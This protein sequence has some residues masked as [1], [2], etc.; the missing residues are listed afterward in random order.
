MSLKLRNS[1]NYPQEHWLYNPFIDRNFNMMVSLEAYVDASYLQSN[2]DKEV[3]EYMASLYHG[4]QG[5]TFNLIIAPKGV[6]KF[7][8]P[9]QGK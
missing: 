6:M 7:V 3:M 5:S 2:D 9:I 4:A 8:Y 1:P